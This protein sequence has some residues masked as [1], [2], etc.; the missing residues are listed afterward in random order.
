M[1]LDVS[2]CLSSIQQKPNQEILAMSREER[3]LRKAMQERAKRE[4]RKA[5][6]HAPE[7]RAGRSCTAGFVVEGG[8]G[9][10]AVWRGPDR[11]RCRPLG[12]SSTAHRSPV[13]P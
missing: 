3:K 1:A 4:L 11:L 9:F 12:E 6:K 2:Q 5:R 13:P 7:I 8:P 10:C